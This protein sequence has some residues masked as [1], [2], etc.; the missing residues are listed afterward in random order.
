MPFP[1]I[2]K[3][4]TELIQALSKALHKRSFPGAQFVTFSLR[5]RDRFDLS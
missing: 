5:A 3:C 4:R 1:R 2:P